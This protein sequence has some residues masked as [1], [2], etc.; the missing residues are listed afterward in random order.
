MT[1]AP[2]Q[3]RIAQILAEGLKTNGIQPHQTDVT[4]SGRELARIVKLRDGAGGHGVAAIDQ[5]TDRDA[6]L[7]LEHL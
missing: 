6:R 4:Q 3:E 2:A 5:D 1:A 7:H